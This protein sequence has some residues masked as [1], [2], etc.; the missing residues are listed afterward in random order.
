[1][2]Q[3]W[4]CFERDTLILSTGRESTPFSHYYYH[5]VHMTH[6]NVFEDIY[7]YIYI[8]S[9]LWFIWCSDYTFY[10]SFKGH[11]ILL[12]ITLTVDLLDLYSPI[13]DIIVKDSMQYIFF[14]FC[15]VVYLWNLH[16]TWCYCEIKVHYQM[17]KQ[18]F[19]S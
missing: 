16:N 17:W 14:L 5:W 19:R 2:C 7:V 8:K 11:L 15:M 13:S 9:H 10:K 12:I 4:L 6:D 3:V 1:M 18:C